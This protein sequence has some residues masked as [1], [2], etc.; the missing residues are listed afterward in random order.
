MKISRVIGGPLL[1]VVALA[2]TGYLL[3]TG[4]RMRNQPHVRTFEAPMRVLPAGTV[5]TE[6][7]PTV[8]G[9]EAAAELKNP[10]TPTPENIQR[11]RVYYRY[12]CL[13]CHG[14]RGDGDGPVGQSYVPTTA[15]LRSEKIEH[16]SDGELYRSILTGTGHSPVLEYTIPPEHRWYL[17]LF[18]RS[19]GPEAHPS[20]VTPK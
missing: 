20:T 8:P 13:C 6:E 9:P 3:M 5:P 14:E 11:G 2:V 1:V 17:V 7:L 18:L 10:L 15:D 19:L 4:P 16:R 12:Y